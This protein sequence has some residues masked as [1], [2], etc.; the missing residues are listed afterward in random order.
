M[1]KWNYISGSG[2]P[3]NKLGEPQMFPELL[4][5]TFGKNYG[6]IIEQNDIIVALTRFENAEIHILSPIIC[7]NGEMAESSKRNFRI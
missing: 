3:L 5:N 6:D 2:N 7:I 4:N 1:T